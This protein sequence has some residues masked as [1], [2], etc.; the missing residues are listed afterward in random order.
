MPG[1]MCFTVRCIRGARNFAETP[2]R[3]VLKIAPTVCITLCRRLY[4]SDLKSERAGARVIG[5]NGR[6]IAHVEILLAGVC[7]TGRDAALQAR[8]ALCQAPAVDPC[9]NL[10]VQVLTFAD[11]C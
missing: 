11:S 4:Q 9:S 6:K 5:H 10:A 3:G 7:V 1:L 2:L 8:H